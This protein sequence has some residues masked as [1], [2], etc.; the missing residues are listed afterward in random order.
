MPAVVCIVNRLDE[1]TAALGDHQRPD[2]DSGVPFRPRGAPRPRPD[3]A[4][5]AALTACARRLTRTAGSCRHGV[6]AS[7]VGS[8]DAGST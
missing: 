2:A 6:F 1:C 8:C 5:R 3:W 7:A 4:G